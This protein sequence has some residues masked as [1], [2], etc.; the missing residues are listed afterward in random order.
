M[1]RAIDARKSHFS[2]GDA[3]FQQLRERDLVPIEEVVQRR[4]EGLRAKTRTHLG[5]PVEDDS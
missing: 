5:Y 2:G 1:T 3:C 4:F